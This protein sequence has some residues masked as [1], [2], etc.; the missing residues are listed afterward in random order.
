[1]SLRLEMLQVAR[2]GPGMLGP[3]ADLVASFVCSQQNPDGGFRDR[4]GRSDLYYT[5]FGVD[6]LTALRLEVPANLAGYLLPHDP[7]QLDFVHAACLARLFSAIPGKVGQ[8][9]IDAALGR[10][11]SFRSP[12]GGY[13]QQPAA[14]AGSSYAC[15]LAYGANAD[16]GRQPPHPGGI[17]DCLRSLYQPD[18][19]WANDSSFPV[20]NVP[21]TAAAVAISK[22]LRLPIPSTT[23]DFLLSAF[24]PPSGGFVPFPGGPLPDLLNTAVALH[25]L[26][27]LQTDFAVIKDSCLDFVDTLWTAEGGFHGH[28]DDDILDL[29]YTYYGLLALGHLAL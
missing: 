24:H 21:A 20:S 19:G 22:N 17:A 23:S 7:A 16:H 4:S 12:D 27:G 6:A 25:A 5:S 18:G 10:L 11:E 29:E 1:M 26:D 13:N 28:W 8:A 15:F 9:A 14:A 3:A 2:L